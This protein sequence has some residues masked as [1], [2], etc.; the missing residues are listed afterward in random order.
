MKYAQLFVCA[1]V[2]L[3]V[4]QAKPLAVQQGFDIFAIFQSVV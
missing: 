1:L 2:V 3:A 4:V